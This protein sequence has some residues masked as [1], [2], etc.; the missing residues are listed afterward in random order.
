M[1]KKFLDYLIFLLIYEYNYNVLTTDNV[2]YLKILY[3]GVDLHIG[4]LIV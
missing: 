4:L 3:Q 1:Q 2:K